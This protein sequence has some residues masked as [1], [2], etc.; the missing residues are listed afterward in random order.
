MIF[1]FREQDWGTNREIFGGNLGYSDFRTFTAIE[2]FVDPA[3]EGEGFIDSDLAIS[4]EFY[5]LYLEGSYN[6]SSFVYRSKVSFDKLLDHATVTINEDR[7]TLDIRL[8]NTISEFIIDPQTNEI[9][10]PTDENNSAQ[11]D[12][13]FEV[14]INV[15]AT[16]KSS[17]F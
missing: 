1:E 15:E 16:S 8:S 14:S 11:I 5:S 2:I 4:G 9:I 12:S 13:L 6:G 7:E 17:L 10:D 3:E